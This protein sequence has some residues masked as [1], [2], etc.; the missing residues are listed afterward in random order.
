MSCNKSDGFESHRFRTISDRAGRPRITPLVETGLTFSARQ[1]SEAGG[2]KVQ[3]PLQF[4][5]PLRGRANGAPSRMCA[6]GYLHTK[7]TDATMFLIKTRR[8][9]RKLSSI[10]V[11]ATLESERR[12]VGGQRCIAIRA[13][14][15]LKAVDVIDVLSALLS[16]R[17]CRRIFGPV[18]GRNSS[19][20]HCGHALM[21]AR[22]AMNF[23]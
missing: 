17:A 7:M 18:T 23:H 10:A 15:R 20:R 8:F 16:C 12:D 6:P 19:P 9:C 11:T 3:Q 13:E 2:H 14:R 21:G 1:F 4:G 22:T 5:V